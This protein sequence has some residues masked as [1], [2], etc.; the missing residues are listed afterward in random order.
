MPLEFAQSLVDESIHQHTACK[1]TLSSLL[2]ESTSSSSS[3]RAIHLP[4]PLSPYTSLSAMP[5]KVLRDPSGRIQGDIGIYPERTEGTQNDEVDPQA[6]T[7]EEQVWS[8][9]YVLGE[10]LRGKGV[11]KEMAAGMVEFGKTWLGVGAIKAVSVM[12]FEL[13]HI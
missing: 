1:T 11:A 5:F 13:Y 12:S 2:A 7:R 9:G 4:V 8:L 10:S 3:S 6:L